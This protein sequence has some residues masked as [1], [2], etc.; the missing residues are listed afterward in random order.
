M[1]SGSCAQQGLTQVHRPTAAN[2]A[3]FLIC[4]PKDALSVVK[5]LR[6]YHYY[7]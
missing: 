6:D 5:L 7:Y 1:K 4:F 3:F 2:W